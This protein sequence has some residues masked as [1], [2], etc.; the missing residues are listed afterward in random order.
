M[1]SS[2]TNGSGEGE[3]RRSDPGEVPQSA[4]QVAVN[5]ESEQPADQTIH[6]RVAPRRAST[7]V[8]SM[9]SDGL[10]SRFDAC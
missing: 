4:D 7:R 1:W 5:T 9:V 8:A 10:Q 3:A 6:G 2:V